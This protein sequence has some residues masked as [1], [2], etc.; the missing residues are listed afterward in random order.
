MPAEKSAPTIEHDM[1]HVGL[2]M[3]KSLTRLV[4]SLA[5]AAA[6]MAAAPATQPAALPSAEPGKIATVSFS[7]LKSYL[8]SPKDKAV[9]LNF[10]GTFCPPCIKELPDLVKLQNTYADRLQVVLVTMDDDTDVP[11]AE[12]LL[13]KL[14][15]AQPTWHIPAAEQEKTLTLNPQFTD[16]VFPTSFLYDKSGKQVGSVIGKAHDFAGWDA[17]VKPHLR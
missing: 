16:L 8:E 4:L 5:F 14:Q 3:H 6:L 1:V 13:K 7:Q 15:I 17:F 2:I 11:A 12:A 10:W 9:L